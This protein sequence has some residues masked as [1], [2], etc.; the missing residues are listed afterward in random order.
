VGRR[1]ATGRIAER[2]S[3]GPAD[4]ST[5]A[6]P[7]RRPTTSRSPKCCNGS[8]CRDGRRDGGPRR[9]DDALTKLLASLDDAGVVFAKPGTLATDV[10]NFSW[11]YSNNSLRY[12]ADISVRWHHRA[13]LR[14]PDTGVLELSGEDHD[15]SN[16]FARL[17]L[18]LDDGSGIALVRNGTTLEIR[19]GGP[20]VLSN[21][22][23]SQIAGESFVINGHAGVDFGPGPIASITIEKGIVTAA[24]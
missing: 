15:V 2:R 16:R 11:R 14:S 8:R 12:G 6:R 3:Q 20:G 18:G 21:M 4:R 23:A 22:A 7:S 10:D 17:V 19:Y 9:R 24:S 5:P 1:P 13:E